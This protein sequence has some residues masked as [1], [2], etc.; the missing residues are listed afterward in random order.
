MSLVLLQGAAPVPASGFMLCFIPLAAIVLGLVAFFVYTDRHAARPYLRLNPFGPANAS[1]PA[2]PPVAP[3]PAANVAPPAAVRPPVVAPP[4]APP[5]VAPS[6]APPAA[7]VPAPTEKVNTAQG[8]VQPGI[9]Q[10]AAPTEGTPTVDLGQSTIKDAVGITYIEYDPPGADLAGEYVRFQNNTHQAITMTGWQLE[11]GAR[12]HTYTFPAFTLPA[13]ATVVL[14][15][16]TGTNEAGNLYWGN[17]AAIW[18]NTGD[19][20][21]LR[22]AAGTEISRFSYTG[23]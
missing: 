9:G 10:A 11:D 7:S 6:V 22:D 19:T 1:T 21:V 8:I 14:W 15:T 4:V 3:A 5:A 13:G 17:R 20:A 12:K 16:K 18:N 2:R 23:K